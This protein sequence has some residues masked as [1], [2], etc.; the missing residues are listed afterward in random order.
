MEREVNNFM[1][2]KTL[3]EAN[4]QRLDKKLKKKKTELDK[5]SVTTKS[6]TK[7][8][9][10]PTLPTASSIRQPVKAS[11]HQSVRTPSIHSP[12]KRTSDLIPR[13]D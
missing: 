12:S 6:E 9:P 2:Q 10:N 8:K 5:N 7:T 1:K 11:D 3:T 4:L 13:D